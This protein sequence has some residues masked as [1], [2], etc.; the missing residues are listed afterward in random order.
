MQYIRH[1]ALSHDAFV[2]AALLHDLGTAP[3]VHSSTSLSFEYSGGLLA[4]SLLLSPDHQAPIGLA[5]SVAEAIIRHQDIG[6]EGNLT[7]VGAVLQIATVLDNTGKFLKLLDK[8]FVRE[9]CS[10]WPRISKSTG[11]TWTGCFAGVVQREM[12]LK[13]WTHTTSLGSGFVD[14]VKG[15][16]ALQEYE[17]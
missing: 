15:N 5:E 9:V 8:G 6:T 13:P 10:K 2:L 11:E 7:I 4:H 14:A 17:R 16:K 1:P 12:D 3:Q